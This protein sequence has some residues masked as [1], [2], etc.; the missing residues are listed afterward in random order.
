MQIAHLNYTDLFKLVKSCHILTNIPL[1][2]R[3]SGFSLSCSRQLLLELLED[4]YA[5]CETINSTKTECIDT[6]ILTHTHT[7]TYHRSNIVS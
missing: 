2:L 3:F 4:K 6:L 7:H 5:K 1:P